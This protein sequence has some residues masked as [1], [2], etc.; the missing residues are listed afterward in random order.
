[1][2]MQFAWNDRAEPQKDI[3]INLGDLIEGLDR[4]KIPSWV[5]NEQLLIRSDLFKIIGECRKIEA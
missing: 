2:E 1:M 5:S 3:W 4:N